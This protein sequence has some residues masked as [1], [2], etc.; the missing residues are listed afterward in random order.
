MIWSSYGDRCGCLD[1]ANLSSCPQFQQHNGGQTHV[2][3]QFIFSGCLSIATGEQ[4]SYAKSSYIT[5]NLPATPKWRKSGTTNSHHL[6]LF[7]KHHDHQ[8]NHC[9]TPTFTW[10]YINIPYS[11]KFSNE[12]NFHI[13]Q[14]HTNGTKIRTYEN[15]WTGRC[16]PSPWRRKKHVPWVK[17]FELAQC[18]SQ[19]GVA[20]RI[21]KIWKLELRNFVL[22]ENLKL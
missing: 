4:H 21:R 18:V 14:V 6:T 3:K 2:F 12:A 10:D 1:Y 13:F 16:V 5:P 8:H 11:G 19:G 20:W 9:T 7:I 17:K 22:T 15:V